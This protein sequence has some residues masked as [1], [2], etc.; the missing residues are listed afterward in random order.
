M[1]RKRQKVASG[2]SEVPKIGVPRKEEKNK[3]EE[4]KGI[5]FIVSH[6]KKSITWKRGY[7]RRK[8]TL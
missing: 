2:M 3:P 4:Q 8:K 7:F 1:K 6:L 5:H